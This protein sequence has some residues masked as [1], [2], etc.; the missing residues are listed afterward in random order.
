MFSD[1]PY[2]FRRL[3]SDYQLFIEE[4]STNLEVDKNGIRM[5]GSGSLGFSLNPDH[6]LTPFSRESDLDVV[7]ISYEIFYKSWIDI[8]N[9]TDDTLLLDIKEKR[10]WKKS[11]VNIQDGFMRPDQMPIKSNLVRTWFPLISGPY[12]SRVAGQHEVKAWLFVS[13]EHAIIYYSKWLRKVQPA[14]LKI[15]VKRGEW[16]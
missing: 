14:L 3:A 2:A 8:L 10:L 1:L 11:L 7:V 12:K 5:I 13:I 4:I 9:F 6:L 16:H 15:F